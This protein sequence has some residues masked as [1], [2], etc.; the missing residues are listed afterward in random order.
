[1]PTMPDTTHRSDPSAADLM[2]RLLTP[3][4]GAFAVLHRPHVH[5]DEVEVLLGDVIT[6]ETVADLPEP[7]GPDLPVL[8][9]VPFRQI[10]ERGFEAVDDG[11][12]LLALRARERV[13]LNLAT[14]LG[15]LP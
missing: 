3:G 13:R 5:P 4:G 7:A 6:A 11:V 9:V 10:R 14:L 15:L 8:A 12:P 1:M 2:V